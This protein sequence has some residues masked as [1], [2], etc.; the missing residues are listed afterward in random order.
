GR[1]GTGPADVVAGARVTVVAGAAVG[2]RRLA[3]C[4]GRRVADPRVVTLIESRTDDRAR[5]DAQSGPAEVGLRAG[6]AIVTA[7]PV[8]EGAMLAARDRVAGVFRARVAVVAVGGSTGD[9]GTGN[10]LVVHAAARSALAGRPVG[11]GRGRART[12]R[13]VAAPRLVARVGRGTDDR[14]AAHAGAGLARVTPRAIVTIVAEAPVR[15]GGI[16]AGTGVRVAR[17]GLVTLI[18]GRAEDRGTP[19]AG[20]ALAG[21]GPR[22]GV[23]VVAERAIALGG[24]LTL[25]GGLVADGPVARV[26]ERRAVSRRPA[27]H[28]AATGVVH[29]AELP[30]VAR[31][32][33]RGRAGAASRRG[34]ADADA[35][36]LVACR[37]DD[38]DP[39]A[40][41]CPAGVGL[42]AEITVAAG[43]A[44]VHGGPL[45]AVRRL[46]ADAVVALV[47]R[48]AAVPR[49]PAAHASRAGVAHG[50]EGAIVARRSV[51]LRGVRARPGEGV[52]GPGVVTLIG[53]RAGDRIAAP[54]DA[55]LADVA[56]RAGIRVVAGAAVGLGGVRA[57]AG[58]R[59][60]GAGVVTRVG[61][62]ADDRIRADAGAAL[63]GVGPGARIAVVA[64]R[65]V[66]LRRIRARARAGITGPGA[67]A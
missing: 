48:G 67:V 49:R 3:A 50:A 58:R 24:A 27:A 6:V 41:A 52:T 19:L 16:R 10:A 28:A 45:A 61:R 35:V 14:I 43:C 17:P 54:A 2:S 30:I 13:G 8:G 9:A 42:G 15:L 31:D 34:V 59:V 20:A 63:A 33:V 11:H 26:E 47:A 39:S 46:V 22:A 53:G 36:A 62:S 55:R 65:T 32:A 18:R 5:P 64:A 57:R 38:G 25:H 4:A 44:V 1:T 56:P 12:A 21:V 60:A 37:A 23:P 29:R 40:Q 51:D 7:G 66:L